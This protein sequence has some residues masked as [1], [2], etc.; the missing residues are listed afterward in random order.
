MRKSHFVIPIEEGGYV[1][2]PSRSYF[3]V[4]IPE[5]TVNLVANPEA[6]DLVGYTATNGTIASAA[7]YQKRGARSL[8]VTPSGA[9]GGVYYSLTG[10]LPTGKHYTFSVDIYG[11]GRFSIHFGNSGGVRVGPEETFSTPGFWNRYSVTIFTTTGIAARTLVVRS[12]DGAPFYVDGFQC[13][14]K[15]YATTFT[16]GNLEAQI[17]TSTPGRL[18]YGWMGVPHRSSSFRTRFVLD[19]GRPVP[20]N[21]LGLDVTDFSGFGYAV[22][23]LF[24]Q[25]LAMRTDWIYQGASLAEK[26]IVIGGI[27][28]SRDL[29]GLIRKRGQLGGGVYGSEGTISP[30]MLHVQF[31]DEQ[32]PV[33]ELATIECVYAG[34]LEGVINN[35]YQ[36]K[37][38]LTFR[39]IRPFLRLD[40]NVAAVLDATRTATSSPISILYQDGTMEAVPSGAYGWSDDNLP[41]RIALAKDGSLYASNGGALLHWTRSGWTV[42]D[43][44]ANALIRDCCTGPDG[45]IYYIYEDDDD[46]SQY[47]HMRRYNPATGT[48]ELNTV[49]TA[50]EFHTS[51]VDTDI[52]MSRVRSDPY[53]NRVYVCGN[54]GG[55]EVGGVAPAESGDRGFDGVAYLDL[56]T[57][58]WMGFP[59]LSDDDGLNYC[60]YDVAP[61]T[62]NICMMVGDFMSWGRPGE[63]GPWS[64]AIY[65]ENN[66]YSGGHAPL[67]W[68]AAEPVDDNT[69]PETLRPRCC[70]YDRKRSVFYVGG[71]FDAYMVKN[72]DEEPWFVYTLGE[73]ICQIDQLSMLVDRVGF[74][75]A[76]GSGSQSWVNDLA[77]SQDGKYLYV[78][79]AFE[80]ALTSKSFL[81]TPNPGDISSMLAYGFATWD[82]EGKVW[83]PSDLRMPSAGAISHLG[84]SVIVAGGVDI[85][86]AYNSLPVPAYTEWYGDLATD[87]IVYNTN[88][89]HVSHTYEGSTYKSPVT[90]V[91][92][93]RGA[94]IVARLEV[95]GP[96]VI[97]KIVNATS[98]RAMN[99]NM[100]VNAGESIV[101]S[102]APGPVWVRSTVRE[103]EYPNLG[104]D[105]WPDLGFVSG[106]NNLV[107]DIDM[108]GEAAASLYWRE[109][110]ASVDAL[111]VRHG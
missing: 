60:V 3:A 42:A 78:A 63:F 49:G 107:L 18:S 7:T 20:L 22:P 86:N 2:S 110:Y 34:G 67:I 68:Y 75:F 14:Q 81:P 46:G 85:T 99:P 1:L 30:I 79:G 26:Q 48:V 91:T 12:V 37:V 53:N 72:S 108:S 66:T 94:R 29:L 21:E 19:A 33:S 111:V 61:A 54:Y 88:A 106:E 55:M 41:Y 77:L 101:F 100:T 102:F 31:Y 105:A 44:I 70:I 104:K 59:V 13:E 36:E 8:A 87:S 97:R 58:T 103:I 15:P 23:E 10:N 11:S 6:V 17:D 32:G 4:V 73:G 95:R 80:R 50:V 27:L 98:G 38:A 83:V 57:N 45:K 24:V 43:N 52:I 62:G 51:F 89:V 40:G 5:D 109:E 25:R 71:T 56:N 65:N 96:A 82:I 76:F 9:N 69:W 39:C 92:M 35:L 93:P 90:V 84:S 47:G 16:S 64:W 74:G 28:S